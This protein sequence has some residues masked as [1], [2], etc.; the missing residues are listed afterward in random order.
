MN[1]SMGR[2]LPLGSQVRLP[3]GRE[4]TIVFN[5]LTGMGIKWGRHDPEPREFDGTFGD[6]GMPTADSPA[7]QSDW[8]WEMDAMLREPELAKRL[9]LPCV[10]EEFELLRYG[11]GET[12]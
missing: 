3:D 12:D 8:P 11:L 2:T 4:G 1:A 5:G 6:V 9:R 10:G 7:R